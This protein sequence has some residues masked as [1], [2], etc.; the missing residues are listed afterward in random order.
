MFLGKVFSNKPHHSGHHSTTL[1]VSTGAPQGCMQSPLL[2]SL[3]THDCTPT[4][5]TNTIIK[6]ADDTTVVWLIS[7]GDESAYKEVAELSE[8]CISN[9]LSLI[10]PRQ[11][12]SSSI[13]GNFRDSGGHVGSGNSGG[14]GGSGDSDPWRVAPQKIFLGEAHHLWGALRR[15]GRRAGQGQRRPR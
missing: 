3:Y 10:P 5:S 2:Y 12:S 6:L 11:R 7:K 1:T 15:R 14:H 4:Y 8:W 9:N 13:S